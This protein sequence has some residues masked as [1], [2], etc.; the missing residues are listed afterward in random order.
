M[1]PS[2]TAE[3][4][5]EESATEESQQMVSRHCGRKGGAWK[6]VVGAG[7]ASM[8]RIAKLGRAAWRRGVLLAMGQRLGWNKSGAH[9]FCSIARVDVKRCGGGRLLAIVSQ[10]GGWVRGKGRRIRRHWRSRR[11][12]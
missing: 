4:L 7:E 2:C 11:D 12:W 10:R 1:M 8:Q 5:L 6:R 3:G 9:R